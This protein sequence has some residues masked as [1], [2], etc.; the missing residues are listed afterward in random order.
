LTIESPKKSVE[1]NRRPAL[2]SDGSESL[3]AIAAAQAFP[4]AVA[5]LGR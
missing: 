1:A 2:S 4:A 5:E 3:L